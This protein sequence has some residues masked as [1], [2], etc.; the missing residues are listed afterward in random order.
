MV[1][2]E[3][4]ALAQRSATAAKETAEK[5][6]ASVAKSRQGVEISGAVAKNFEEIQQEVRSLG[7][8]IDEIAQATQEQSQGIGQ[9]TGSVSKMETVT[10]ANAATAEETAAAAE[11]LNSQ[12]HML[13]ESVGHLRQLTEG[14]GRN[15]SRAPLALGHPT[16][17]SGPR[18]APK[19]RPPVLAALH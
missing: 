15:H 11:E 9:V 13:K 17:A 6:E 16:A 4:R 5:I 2:E 19:L 10:Q 14:S 12:S 3:V 18:R 1:A 8:L 7:H